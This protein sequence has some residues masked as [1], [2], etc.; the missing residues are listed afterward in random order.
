MEEIVGAYRIAA[1]QRSDFEALQ[2]YDDLLTMLDGASADVHPDWDELAARWLDVL[3]GL[4]GMSGCL[5]R[6]GIRL[7]S[8]VSKRTWKNAH[9]AFEK[10]S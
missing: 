6:D 8:G 3:F 9:P 7:R 2:D 4:F 10:V 5:S 1:S